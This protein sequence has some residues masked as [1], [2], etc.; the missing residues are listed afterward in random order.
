MTAHA[1]GVFAQLALHFFQA[2]QHRTRM[3]QQAFA[4]RRQVN[5]AGMAVQQRRIQRGFEVAQALADGRGRNEFA[6]GHLA[7]AAQLAHGDEQLQRGQ[8]DAS[9]EV[10]F[11]AFDGHGHKVIVF[12]DES[13]FCLDII[14]LVIA[15]YDGWLAKLERYENDCLNVKK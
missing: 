13:Q 7:N 2:E 14:I 15:K 4:R 5:P 12:Y 3:V 9:G 8:V 6:L 10:A 1:I 11:R